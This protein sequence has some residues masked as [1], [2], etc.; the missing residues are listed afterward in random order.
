MPVDPAPRREEIEDA[1]DDGA[2]F[3]LARAVRHGHDRAAHREA[4]AVLGDGEVARGGARASERG[5]A[6]GVLP[7]L[8]R[9]ADAIADV[10]GELVGHPES[11]AECRERRRIDPGDRCAERGGGLEE[12][13]GL[14]AVV[15]GDV[16]VV[17]E[18]PRLTADESA[19]DPRRRSEDRER[20]RADVGSPFERAREHVEREHDEAVADE[21]RHRV[22]P[23]LVHGR[24]A[25]PQLRG[26]EARE[27]VV[28][29]R[30]AVEELD[31]RRRRVRERIVLPSGRTRRR[32]T[33]PRPDARASREHRVHER[34][35]QLRRR[36]GRTARRPHHGLAQHG[37]EMH[38]ISHR[39]DGIE[40][41][42]DHT[43]RLCTMFG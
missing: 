33:E 10:V 38:R 1:L 12:R 7:E 4:E 32:E 36:R 22:S 8:C 5:V 6:A 13:G 16:D 15:R 37:L 19:V 31:G 34:V 9:V 23:D 43:G 25:A 41:R 27:I 28:G 24:P 29:Q 17:L 3:G 21:D 35:T 26:V 42:G 39:H 2:Q 14:R 30:S 40:Q 11:S 20:T 18:L